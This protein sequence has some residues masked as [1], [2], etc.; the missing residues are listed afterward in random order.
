M[1]RGWIKATGGDGWVAGILDRGAELC[2]GKEL[3]CAKMHA[4]SPAPAPAPG[5]ALGE[6]AEQKRLLMSGTPALQPRESEGSNYRSLT[7]GKNVLEGMQGE[8]VAS[9]A[10]HLGQ[11]DEKISLSGN[12]AP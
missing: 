7:Q 5:V 3:G 6:R 1:L 8:A 12:L 4:H 2:P 11:R 9:A 10:G